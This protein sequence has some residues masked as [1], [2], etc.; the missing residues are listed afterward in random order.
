MSI[1]NNFRHTLHEMLN[2]TL[3]QMFSN[4]ILR[5]TCH[6]N[7]IRALS[8]QIGQA[9]QLA[10]CFHTSDKDAGLATESVR[11]AVPVFQE[12][13]NRSFGQIPT[14]WLLQNLT[15]GGEI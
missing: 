4:L 8:I 5:V 2:G 14:W 7:D 12:S 3:I 15:P 11:R 13:T 10:D 9:K 6:H 1:T